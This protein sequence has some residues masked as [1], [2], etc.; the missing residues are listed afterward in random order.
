MI[1][2]GTKHDAG[3]DDVERCDYKWSDRSRS[4]IESTIT[5]IVPSRELLRLPLIPPC[6]Y[7][8]SLA[9]PQTT[10]NASAR[11]ADSTP[12]A[13]CIT[14]IAV[15]LSSIHYRSFVDRLRGKGEIGLL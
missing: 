6:L 4:S 15:E 5:M 7:I 13:L 10:E 11:T 14:F 9:A 12:Q 1:I 8:L 2:D 3:L